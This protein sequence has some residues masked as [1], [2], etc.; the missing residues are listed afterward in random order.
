M[1]NDSIKK[2][3]SYE[4]AINDIN[5]HFR[6]LLE[7]VACGDFS[8]ASSEASRIAASSRDL[9]QSINALG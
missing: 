4:K 6:A 7:S 2:I 5:E 1:T 8:S 3:V 9:S